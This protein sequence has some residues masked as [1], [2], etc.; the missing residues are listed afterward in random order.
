[1][2]CLL[3]L[4]TSGIRGN[5]YA[6]LWAREWL[7][8]LIFKSEWLLKLP[9]MNKVPQREKELETL[10]PVLHLALKTNQLLSS[11]GD[12]TGLAVSW[13]CWVADLIPDRAVG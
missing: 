7:G 2:A 3:K 11:H 8:P 10:G 4:G 1:M 12:E 5:H 13:E 6:S 9:L